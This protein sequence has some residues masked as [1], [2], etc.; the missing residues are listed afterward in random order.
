[1]IQTRNAVVTFI[2][3]FTLPGLDRDYPAGDYRVNVDEEQL[4]VSFAGSRRVA[5]T[6]MLVSGATT[7]AWPVDPKDLEAALAADGQRSARPEHDDQNEH[8]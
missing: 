2:A 5:T 8:R 4:D 3:P 1:M 7:L 6:I